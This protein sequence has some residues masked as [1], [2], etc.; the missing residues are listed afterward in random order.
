MTVISLSTTKGGC[1]KTTTVQIMGEILG[2][3]GK[4]VLVIDADPQCNLSTVS[5]I[6]ISED[7]YQTNNLYTLIK[8]QSTIDKCI[9]KCEYYDILV[10]S[11]M[12][13]YA[14]TEYGNIAGYEFMLREIIE[15]LDYDVVLIDTPPTLGK[16]GIM[17]LTASD[18]VIVP[19]ECSKMSMLGFQQL[20]QTIG[21]VKKRTNKGLEI[22]GVLV[23]KFNK[24]T[25]WDGAVYDAL[26]QMAESYNTK[27][28]NTKIRETIK[29]REAQGLNKRVIDF[30][31]NMT[32]VED[33]EEL[34]N[35]I[36]ED[37]F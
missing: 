21:S 23:L 33:Y 32:A 6:M 30:A 34:I 20:T 29:V 16:I 25:N 18:Y 24:R 19:S 22:L 37:I 14:E 4:K 10:G 13:T 36:S 31:K 9:E 28:F 2:K 3:K 1:G 26:E 11:L 12:M 27:V 35:E 15:E 8:E 7:K 17:A 5:G